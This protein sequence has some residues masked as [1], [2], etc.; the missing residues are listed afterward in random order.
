MNHPGLSPTLWPSSPQLNNPVMSSV[1]YRAPHREL[2]LNES[3]KSWWRNTQT[4]SRG[5][6]VGEGNI[7]RDRVEKKNKTADSLL[8][9]LAE[10]IEAATNFS[11]PLL[12]FL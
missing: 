11:F 2:N 1:V 3:N 12:S 6:C 5:L 4:L 10:V 9:K 8:I 7:R